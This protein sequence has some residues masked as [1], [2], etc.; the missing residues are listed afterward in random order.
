MIESYEKDQ[1]KP[2]RQSE[3]RLAEKPLAGAMGRRIAESRW[4]L[5]VGTSRRLK[6]KPPCD[7]REKTTLL[8]G[9]ALDDPEERAG[10]HRSRDRQKRIRCPRCCVEPRWETGSPRRL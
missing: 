7:G 2:Q 8:S 6:I 3:A 9:T 10:A 4:Y 1:A 5:G